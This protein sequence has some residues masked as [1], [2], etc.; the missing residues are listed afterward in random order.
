MVITPP[1]RTS[2]EDASTY[3]KL[4]GLLMTQALYT[5]FTETPMRTMV[6]RKIGDYS[7][8][9]VALALLAIGIALAAGSAHFD[10]AAWGDSNTI[11]ILAP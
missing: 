1:N 10:Q 8:V 7:L 3:L 2:S 6:Q 4:K 9:H 11:G 5:C